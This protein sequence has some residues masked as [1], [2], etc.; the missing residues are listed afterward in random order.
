MLVDG[1]GP[2]LWTRCEPILSS[3]R[4]Y[5]F[6]PGAGRGLDLID[7][8]R[9]HEQ[10]M[11]DVP[12]RA[13]QIT[14]YEILKALILK[15]RRSQRGAR[16]ETRDDDGVPAR[17]R[18]RTGRLNPT[19]SGADVGSRDTSGGSRPG[20][21]DGAQLSGAEAAILG[22]VAGSI[23]AAVTHPFDVVRTR[24]MTCTNAEVMGPGL[25]GLFA[26]LGPRV[27]LIGPSCA[28]FFVVYE[29]VK[30]YLVAPGARVS[31]S[32]E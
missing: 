18:R 7:P 3:R 24:L 15:T 1:D 27:L 5:T 25:R 14:G 23:S 28:V 11:R 8:C 4:S 19:A 30:K 32:R 9:C 10:V 20:V 12:F 26:G 29:G 16:P 31:S 13:I 17:S 22:A 21:A 6:R 2:G